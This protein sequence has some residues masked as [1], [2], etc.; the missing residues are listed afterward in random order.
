MLCI[1]FFQLE[2]PFTDAQGDF[3][4]QLRLVYEKCAKKRSEQLARSADRVECRHPPEGA[5][6]YAVGMVVR[7]K[8]STLA[9]KTGVIVSWDL[10]CKK[11][12][13]WIEV[14]EIRKL[15][16][17]VDQPFYCTLNYYGEY[18]YLAEGKRN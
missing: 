5:L 16:R 11:P 10:Y 9:Q 13:K 18:Y 6:K 1:F 8:Y 17:G 7:G 14:Q 12:D 3:S 15:T 4:A 2:A